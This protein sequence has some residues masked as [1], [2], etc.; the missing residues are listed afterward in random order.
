[1]L[2]R[3]TKIVPYYRIQTVIDARTVFQRR[4]DLATVTVDTAGSLSLGGQDAAA[5]D[6]SGGRADDI[7]DE[8]EIRLDRAVD[9]YRAGRA[10]IGVDDEYDAGTAGVDPDRSGHVDGDPSN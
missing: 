6:I 4:L 9:A 3:R 8:L 5:V 1:M 7:R 10:G 2:R